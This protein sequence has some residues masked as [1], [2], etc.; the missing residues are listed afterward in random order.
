MNKAV[1]VH[2]DP[3]PGI[4]HLD[5]QNRLLY[6]LEHHNGPEP[7]EVWQLGDMIAAPDDLVRRNLKTL[8]KLGKVHENE[9]KP[10][11]AKSY[12]LRPAENHAPVAA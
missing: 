2:R 7:L 10:G 6:A 8:I 9:A 11:L 5:I 4:E 1:R 3:I 12:V